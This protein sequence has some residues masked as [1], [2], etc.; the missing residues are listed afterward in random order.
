MD[1]LDPAI[2]VITP[3][4]AA[5]AIGVDVG[6]SGQAMWLVFIKRT[7]EPWY[8]RNPYI[9][10]APDISEGRGSVSPFLDVP[11]GLEKHVERYK[12]NGWLSSS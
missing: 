12:T 7:G 8:F 9:R 2:E 4:G 6:E 1:R 10:Q 5:Q 3:L 11:A